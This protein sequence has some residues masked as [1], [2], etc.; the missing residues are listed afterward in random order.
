MN[1]IFVHPVTLNGRSHQGMVGFKFSCVCI[2]SISTYIDIHTHKYKINHYNSIF[3]WDLTIYNFLGVSKNGHFILFV[4]GFKHHIFLQLHTYV[5]LNASLSYKMPK[6]YMEIG[7][8]NNKKCE[9]MKGHEW[10]Y[11]AQLLYL[12]LL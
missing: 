11:K 12:F 9:K 5:V 10:F 2:Y 1:V 4:K 3:S 7:C 8:R 6:E